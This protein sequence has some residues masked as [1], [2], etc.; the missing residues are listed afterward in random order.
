M[1][2]KFTFILLILTG[3]ISEVHAKVNTDSIFERAI[4]L[5][6]SQHFN[7]A[8][9]DAKKA[10]SYNTKRGDIIVFLANAYSMDNKSDTA[11]MYIQ[12][13]KE[14]GYHNDDYYETWTNILLRDHQYL[15]LLQAC[16]EAE[17][18]KYPDYEDLF[19]KRL[20]AYTELKYY[21]KGI[22]LIETPKNKGYLN[23]KKINDVYSYLIYERNINTLSVNYSLNM[24]DKGFIPQHIAS[25]GYSLRIGENGLGIDANYI[26]Q[27]NLNYVQLK[28]NF[29]IS[30]TEEQSI[31]FNYGYAYK[32]SLFPQ[33]QASFEYYINFPDQLE[34]SFGARFMN[35]EKLNNNFLI[36]TA[37]IGKYIEDNYFAIRPYYVF[38]NST[39]DKSFSLMSNY[40]LF[41][42]NEFDFWNIEI[43]YGNMPDDLY[44]STQ[45]FGF[46]QLSSYKI[47][48][49]KNF[50]I[51]RTSDF[52]IGAGY[53]NEEIKWYLYRNRLIVD[54][55]YQIRLK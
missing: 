11:F 37:H 50:R 25:L 23:D 29:H 8:I 13:A 52:H 10:L 48:L 3:L 51:N 16:N 4:T 6:K 17:K 44:S 21:D 45:V 15:A 26:N 7:L 35:Y 20:T 39:K 1:K 41:G 24:L 14:I 40:K 31:Y 30:L 43:D 47:K 49:E 34:S 54:V 22:H 12:W 2:T 9:I 53:S 28:A 46:S 19:H 18:Q 33:H 38:N 55:G 42:S 32:A 27:Q 5:A 36:L